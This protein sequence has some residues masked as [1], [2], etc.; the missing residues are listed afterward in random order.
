MYKLQVRITRDCSTTRIRPKDNLN[1]PC[2]LLLYDYNNFN[3]DT[4]NDNDDKKNINT[5]NTLQ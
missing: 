5:L 2:N 3:N 1:L 4:N